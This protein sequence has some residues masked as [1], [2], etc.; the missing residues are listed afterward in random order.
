MEKCM[1]ML[2]EIHAAVES[3]HGRSMV[4]EFGKGRSAYGVYSEIGK[5]LEEHD[6]ATAKKA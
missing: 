1:E 5:M 2:R 6:A 3:S 4:L